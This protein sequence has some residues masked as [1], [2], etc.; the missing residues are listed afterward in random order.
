MIAYVP[1]I[2]LRLPRVQVRDPAHRQAGQVAHDYSGC[3]G[4]RNRQCSDARGLA[5][6]PLAAPGDR[7][8][9]APAM[10]G[11]AGRFRDINRCS[12]CGAAP[13]GH[14]HRGAPALSVLL[15]WITLTLATFVFGA[16]FI[17]RIIFHG[18]QHP[19]VKAFVGG[20]MLIVALHIPW[21]YIVVWLAM[22]FLG[23][24]AQLLAIYEKRPWRRAPAS[25][26]LART[27]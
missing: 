2:S 17:G 18:N 12:A 8:A 7:P 13:S 24:G 27:R 4:D 21:L 22:V 16:Y 1:G 25:E 15:V 11:A 10:E 14:G 19:V 3:L 5:L 6:P 23:L 9:P 26:S 20:L